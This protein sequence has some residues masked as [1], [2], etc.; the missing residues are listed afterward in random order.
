MPCRC[1]VTIRF[2][3]LFKHVHEFHYHPRVARLFFASLFLPFAVALLC[4]NFHQRRWNPWLVFATP[5]SVSMGFP[6][7]RPIIP[8]ISLIRSGAHDP[9]SSSSSSWRRFSGDDVLIDS[10]TVRAPNYLRRRP[11]RDKDSIRK[12]RRLED[13][14]A[15]RRWTSSVL[16]TSS[17]RS[18]AMISKTITLLS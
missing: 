10:I 14:A 4:T 12:W 6:T 1:S 9:P 18:I 3:T 17:V 11:P 8:L 7:Y 2:L 5:G 16:P 13:I 15:H